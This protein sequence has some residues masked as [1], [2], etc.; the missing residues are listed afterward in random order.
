MENA[1]SADSRRVRRRSEDPYQSH[2]NRWSLLSISASVPTRAWAASS[3]ADS[4][5]RSPPA[6]RARQVR[7]LLDGYG[8]P[9]GDRVGF[10]DKLIGFAVRAA[11]AEAVDHRVTPD[12]P[13][14]TDTGYPVLWAVTW[15]IRSAAWILG[16]R[17]FLER[18]L[19]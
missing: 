18:A 5:G 8:L 19:Q 15:R 17:A 1:S 10:V 9:A 16:H 12:S 3:S 14:V 13:A 2:T 7:L 11:R 4:H 6:V